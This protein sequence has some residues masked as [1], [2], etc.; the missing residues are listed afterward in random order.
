MEDVHPEPAEAGFGYGEVDLQIAAETLELML[1]HEL[2]RRLPDHLRRQ[3]HPV[4]RHDLALD[5]D[6]DRCIGGDEDVRRPLV[7]H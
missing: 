5:L 1:V 3:L 7:G 2:E 6:H 4:D